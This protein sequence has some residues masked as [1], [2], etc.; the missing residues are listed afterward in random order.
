MCTIKCWND[1]QVGQWRFKK[2][3]RKIRADENLRFVECV[4]DYK[5][6]EDTECRCRKSRH[7]F[8]QF[9]SE[10]APT[11]I[12]IQDKVRK[13]IRSS[14]F[15][16]I[17]SEQVTPSSASNQ[18]NQSGAVH[19]FDEPMKMAMDHMRNDAYFRFLQSEDYLTFVSIVEGRESGRK[20]NQ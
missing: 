7:I 12:H 15:G 18:S 2:Y 10:D 4:Q 9:L 6:L 16:D 17:D 13:Q 8:L 3:L 20:Q 5:K 14:I 11:Q 1:F 19:L